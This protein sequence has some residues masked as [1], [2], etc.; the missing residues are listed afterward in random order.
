MVISLRISQQ[1]GVVGWGGVGWGGRVGGASSYGQVKD[2][3][4]FLK[5]YCITDFRGGGNY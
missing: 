4:Q 3:R 1:W 2:A 5:D